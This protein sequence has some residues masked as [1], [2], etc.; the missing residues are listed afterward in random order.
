MLSS[1]FTANSLLANFA[2][3]LHNW[4]LRFCPLWFYML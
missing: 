4:V 1:Y 2:E 3:T